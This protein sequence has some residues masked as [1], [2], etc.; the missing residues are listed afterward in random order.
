MIRL[1]SI[2]LTVL[3]CL[4][5][6]GAKRT[7]AQ[8]V[9]VD[10]GEDGTLTIVEEFVGGKNPPFTTVYI[11][12]RFDIETE[13]VVVSLSTLSSTSFNGHTGTLDF[14]ADDVHAIEVTNV[15][16]VVVSL[17]PISLYADLT[18]QGAEIVAIEG[19]LGFSGIVGNTT[20]SSG[21]GHGV[22]SITDI[23][24]FGNL[25]ISTGHASDSVQFGRPYFPTDQWGDVF[26]H[27]DLSINTGHDND[28]LWNSADLYVGGDVDIQLGQGRDLLLGEERLITEPDSDVTISLGQQ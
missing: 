25:S 8:N 14:A 10:L 28:E 9:L 21:W 20:I 18:I 26:V 6:V 16:R 2:S 15:D 23:Q 12:P 22:V 24:L 11:D 4:I 19:F 13:T 1:F 3:T 17:I 5:F 27:G 7:F